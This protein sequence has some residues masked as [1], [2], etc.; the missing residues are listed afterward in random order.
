MSWNDD[1]IQSQK[2]EIY[3]N[4]YT[5]KNGGLARSK[6]LDKFEN[7]PQPIP[8]E[9][10]KEDKGNISLFGGLGISISQTNQNCYI[11][12]Q[13]HNNFFNMKD[14]NEIKKNNDKSEEMCQNL[15]VENENIMLKN[16]WVGE[17][18]TYDNSIFF[19]DK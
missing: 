4:L 12:P 1:Q 5:S 16:E 2:S 18:K 14:F 13:P 15:I 6:S 10:E 8:M 3:F 17:L 9:E 19:F 11:Q 7:K